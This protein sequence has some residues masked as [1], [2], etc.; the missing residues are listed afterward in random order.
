MCCLQFSTPR[1]LKRKYTN[2]R[3]DYICC[4]AYS[5]QLIK[6]ITFRH[7]LAERIYVHT[8]AVSRSAAKPF[9]G[10]RRG[11]CWTN[12]YNEDVWI[13]NLPAARRFVVAASELRKESP[14]GSSTSSRFAFLNPRLPL[15]SQQQSTIHVEEVPIKACRLP[16]GGV[17]LCGS[18]TPAHRISGLEHIYIAHRIE[19]IGQSRNLRRQGGQQNNTPPSSLV[20][21]LDAP[22]SRAA[23]GFSSQQACPLARAPLASSPRQLFSSSGRIL[24]VPKHERNQCLE[25]KGACAPDDIDRKSWGEDLSARQRRVWRLLI[26]QTNQG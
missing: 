8:A 23:A 25:A 10:S 17:D 7:Q 1:R 18:R 16:R 24:L 20:L 15:Q 4:S 13:Q 22:A 14:R 21:H 12:T 11:S 19:S 5:L 3:L 6:I 9:T 26:A 2:E